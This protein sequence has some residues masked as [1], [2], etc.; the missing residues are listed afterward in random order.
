MN[1]TIILFI[2]DHGQRWGSF[3]STYAGMLE[4]RM[5]FVYAIFPPWFRTRYPE[6]WQ[7][8]VANTRRLT[9]SFDL[10]STLVDIMNGAYADLERT[11]QSHHGQSLFTMVPLNR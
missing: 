4:E 7:N 5:P 9:A 10:Y 2:S 3:R 8:L 1:H 6:V 11:Y